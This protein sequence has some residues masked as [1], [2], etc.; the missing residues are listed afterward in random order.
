VRLKASLQKQQLPFMESRWM[1][2]LYCTD[3]LGKQG[4]EVEIT[5]GG[6]HHIHRTYDRNSLLCGAGTGVGDIP[7]E[8]S[9]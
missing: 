2:L 5:I 8:C 3:L 7:A 9:H 6:Y 1:V 4:K